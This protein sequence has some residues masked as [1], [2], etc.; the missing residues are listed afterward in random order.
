M[1]LQRY[2]EIMTERFHA[3][4]TGA[5]PLAAEF[6]HQI[7]IFFE[8]ERKNAAAD[9]RPRFEHGDVPVLKRIGGR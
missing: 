2:F 1:V 9:A 4:V 5:D 8:V 7:G 6:A 3:L